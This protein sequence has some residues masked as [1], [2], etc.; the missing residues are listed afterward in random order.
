[1][2]TPNTRP[3]RPMLTELGR[4]MLIYSV[5]SR[6]FK[7]DL[8]KS[9]WRII[10]LIQFQ[11]WTRTG[12]FSPYSLRYSSISSAVADSPKAMV[13]GSP[14]RNCI[15]MNTRKDTRSTSTMA[16]NTFF[17]MYFVMYYLVIVLSQ[18]KRWKGGN[19][20]ALRAQ[21]CGRVPQ[22]GT[23]LLRREGARDHSAQRSFTYPARRWPGQP[24]RRRSRR[25]RNPSRSR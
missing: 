10:L 7:M 12:S 15:R 6:A 13:A 21:P 25:C 11:Y 2:I 8:P 3:G 4:R 14:G 16:V 18:Y 5:T 17:I 24:R 1:M 9:Q 19:R 23:V 20:N 22:G